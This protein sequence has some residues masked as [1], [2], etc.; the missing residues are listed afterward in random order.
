[1]FYLEFLRVR[2][3]FVWYAATLVAVVLLFIYGTFAANHA[4]IQSQVTTNGTTTTEHLHGLHSIGDMTIPI[5]PVLAVCG[6]FALIFGSFFA[7]SFN[8]T[9]QHAH[10]TFVRP[11]SRSRMA[12]EVASVDVAAI[13]GALLFAAALAFVTMSIVAVTIGHDLHFDWGDQWLATALLALGC[14]L[15]WYAVLQAVSAW[16]AER[17]GSGY[18]FGIAIAVLASAQGLAHATFLG[19]VFVDIFKAILFIDPLAY[20]SSVTVD[21][22]GGATIDSYFAMPIGE[23]ALIVWVL[24]AVAI[25]LASIEWKRVEI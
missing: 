12:L 20:F 8:R 24:A 4:D 1:M 2:R 7:S 16:T 19:P 11:V 21:Q 9:S 13:L 23:R 25:V 15:M 22:H 3:V 14:A 5:G 18:I 17:R 6:V 10:F